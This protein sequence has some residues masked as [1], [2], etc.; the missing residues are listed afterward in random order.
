M[1]LFRLLSLD[2]SAMD[3]YLRN[4]LLFGASSPVTYYLSASY[5]LAEACVAASNALSSSFKTLSS[6][7]DYPKLQDLQTS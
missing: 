5:W 3:C 7:Q 4:L 2:I 1:K 6:S